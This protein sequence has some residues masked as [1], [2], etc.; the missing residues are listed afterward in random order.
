VLTTDQKLQYDLT[1]SEM[2]IDA[3]GLLGIPATFKSVENA[4]STEL[5]QSGKWQLL[6]WKCI[7]FSTCNDL[8]TLNAR[9]RLTYFQQEIAADQVSPGR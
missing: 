2:I 3:I 9:G 8:H 7:V 1:G 6:Q 4:T 5:V